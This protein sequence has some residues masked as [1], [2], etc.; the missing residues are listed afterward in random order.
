MNFDS[1][2]GH[3]PTILFISH[4]ASLSGAPIVFLNIIRWLRPRMPHRFRVILRTGG[5]LER[6]F[7]KVAEVYLLENGTVDRSCLQDVCLIYSNTATNGLFLSSLP[8]GDIP[9]I[10]HIH[11]MQCAL[12]WNGKDN[13]KQIRK[14]SVHIIACSNAVAQVLTHIYG[15]DRNHVTAIPESIYP[16]EVQDRSKLPSALMNELNLSGNEFVVVSS[17]TVHLQKGSDLFIQLASYCRERLQPDQSIRFFWIGG[18]SN[19][20]S[21]GLFEHDARKLGL[22]GIIK[23]LGETDNPHPAI[24][25]ADVFCLPSREDSF[26]LVMLEAGALGKPVLAFRQSGGA[27]EYCSKGGGFLF[28]YLDVSAMGEFILQRAAHRNTLISAG[29]KA[30]KLVLDEFSLDVTGPKILDL[31]QRFSRRTAMADA[32]TAQLFL[33]TSTGAYTEEKSQKVFI[34]TKV[35]NYLKF[36]LS[37]DEW[38]DNFELRFDPIDRIAAINISSMTL[39]SMRDQAI[40]WKANTPVD[41]DRIVVEGTAARIPDSAVLRLQS[42]GSDPILRIPYRKV[43]RSVKEYQLEITLSVQTAPVDLAAGYPPLLQQIEDL[44]RRHFSME[45]Q[46]KQWRRV[47]EELRVNLLYSKLAQQGREIYIWGSG[48]AARDLANTLINANGVFRGFIDR[49]ESMEGTALLGHPIY[50]K[51]ILKD[52]ELARAFIIIASTSWRD[53]QTELSEINFKAEVDCTPSP[54]LRF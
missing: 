23:F 39:K 18:V 47:S 2:S 30:R 25:S 4:E 8:I 48:S 17:G 7:G 3:Q 19:E 31:I 29:E 33:P 53:I 49:N 6:E 14:H 22:D 43:G 21:S 28:P 12:D 10:T 16:S 38:E 46:S 5:P 51:S 1:N 40:L 50:H 42:Y 11:E 37:E 52:P 36:Q 34:K 44:R 41:F 45:Q 35:D 54:L 32:G 24:A 27:E 13:L 9:V 26:P 20:F 15:I